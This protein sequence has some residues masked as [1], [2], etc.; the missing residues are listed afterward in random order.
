MSLG[1][2]DGFEVENGKL[3]VTVQS[4]SSLIYQLFALGE[5]G[6]VLAI[7]HSG[8]ATVTDSKALAMSM[9]DDLATFLRSSDSSEAELYSFHGEGTSGAPLASTSLIDRYCE[10]G[11]TTEVGDL[12]AIACDAAEV[13]TGALDTSLASQGFTLGRWR[14]TPT[15][16]WERVSKLL[17]AAGRLWTFPSSRGYASSA[18]WPW[19]QES[20]LTVEVTA[21]G[22]MVTGAPGSATGATLVRAWLESGGT[23]E[24]PVA[25]D[26]SFALAFSGELRGEK[27]T[28]QAI[29][30]IDATGNKVRLRIPLGNPGG[31]LDLSAGGGARRVARDGD[32]VA[33]VPAE[34]DGSGFAHVR[35]AS[36]ASGL[37]ALSEV[38]VEGPVSDAE[39]LDGVLY[40]GG[41]RLAVFDLADPT[42]PFAQAEVDIFAGSPVEA[43]VLEGGRLWA[44]GAEGGSQRLLAVDLASALAPVAVPAESLLVANVAESRLLARDGDLYRLGTARVERYDLPPGLPPVPTA[45]GSPAGVTITDLESAEGVLFVAARGQGARELV[46]AAGVFTLGA[47]PSPAHAAAGLFAIPE[48][49]GERLWRAAGLAGAA[50]NDSTKRTPTGCLL[51]DVVVSAT[52]LLLVTGCGIEREVLP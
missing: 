30:E 17:V 38:T 45:T 28:L 7:T 49:G 5:P 15:E 27:V 46:E 35:I 24:V 36:T 18:L 39:M 52:D 44:L 33:V 21:S 47:A 42:N 31:S 3:H 41:A 26:G 9:V 43:L 29:F 6:E 13:A 19:L 25:T 10:R 12:F 32:L 23:F 2:V 51:R 16:S 48:A 40:V 22:A 50:E 20:S 4:G 14:P 37:A 1:T 8:N 11:S 34:L